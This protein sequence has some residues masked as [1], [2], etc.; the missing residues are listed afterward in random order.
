MMATLIAAMAGG[1]VAP[2]ILNPNFWF[3]LQLCSMFAITGFAC[4]VISVFGALQNGDIVTLL[5]AWHWIA[6]ADLTSATGMDDED[7]DKAE[8]EMEEN[9]SFLTRAPGILRRLFG[10]NITSVTRE[11]RTRIANDSEEDSVAEYTEWGEADVSSIGRPH[12]S[13]VQAQPQPQPQPRAAPQ[14]QAAQPL[15]RRRVV[16][17]ESEESSRADADA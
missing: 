9:N 10:N 12:T 4:G 13:H 16:A 6:D 1:M 17:A 5:S 2:R 15:I 3:H 7:M 11:R 14:A 8:Q